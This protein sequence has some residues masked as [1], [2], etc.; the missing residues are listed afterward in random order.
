MKLGK[1]LHYKCIKRI[2]YLGVHLTE[3]VQDFYT[4][5]Y[6][7][8]LKE[9]K[10]NLNKWRDSPCLWTRTLNIVKTAIPSKLIH[11]FSA[12]S[13]KIPAGLFLFSRR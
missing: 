11:R 13:I 5:N 9:V 12:I 7:A 6:K 2:K 3:D 4:E 1:Q 8:L 10:E